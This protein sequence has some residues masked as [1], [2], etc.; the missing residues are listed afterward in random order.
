M[1][2]PVFLPQPLSSGICVGRENAMTGV[3]TRAPSHFGPQFM[4]PSPYLGC[5]QLRGSQCYCSN[6]L[7]LPQSFIVG[8]RFR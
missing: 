4:E 1:G 8:I 5:L 2:W 6:L 3:A 7:Q